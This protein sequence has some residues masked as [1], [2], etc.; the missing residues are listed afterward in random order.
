MKK[1]FTFL[2]L[3]TGAIFCT[4]GQ[5]PQGFKYQTVIR[6]GNSLLTNQL[7][8]I[9]TSILQSS[10][11]GTAMFSQV[12]TI[13][14][15]PY[16]LVNLM[17]G[18]GG[19]DS[20]SIQ[21]IDWS[22]GPYFIKTELD[23]SGGTNFHNMGI[24]QIL[25]VPFAMFS[26]KTNTHA[27]FEIDGTS[28]LPIDTA[29]FEVKDRAGRT[30]FAVY[31]EGAVVYV[32]EGA[33]GAKSGFTVGGRTPGGKGFLVDEIMRVTPD[34][35]RFY[36]AD[37]SKT[38]GAVRGFSVQGRSAG[39]TS[40]ANV[41]Y[42]T[43]DSTRIYT[44][45][46]IAGFGIGNVDKNHT[47]SSYMKINGYNTA[48]GNMAGKSLKH[49][50]WN[51]MMGYQ[52]GMNSTNAFQN[53]FLG[54]NAGMSNTTGDNNIFIGSN[55][56]IFN[57]VGIN[58][59]FIGDSAGYINQSGNYNVYIGLRSGRNS[60]GNANVFVGNRTGYNL[61]QG[62]GNTF[63]GI[64]AGD[65]DYP[66]SD[67]GNVYLGRFAGYNMPGSNQLVISNSISDT[68]T[69][70]IYGEFYKNKLRIN[71]QL[72]INMSATVNAL[73]VNGNAYKTAAGSWLVASDARIKS[74]I[75]EID[76]AQET[77]LKLHPV[78]F[79]YTQEWISKNPGLE[80][81][82]YYN[83]LAQEFLNVFPQ[84]VKSSGQFINGDSK[85]LLQMDSYNA[86][87]IMVKAVQELIL[88]NKALEKRV[89]ELASEMEKLK[90]K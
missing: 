90:Q 10:I 44:R 86:Q 9:K 24:S 62:N 67:S 61:V 4:Y 50:S 6:K 89:A 17:I 33:K 84:S 64:A 11:T 63:V 53:V 77:L 57:T 19:V 8:S 7:V 45:D 38:K 23:E 21:S 72:G 60:I 36:I 20:G 14:T 13:T 42:V 25:S 88:E 66:T 34:S 46:T 43:S 37:S 54:Y 1:L 40:G 52:A 15:N 81:Q 65:A 30:V 71:K 56:G 69:S 35:I 59:S 5:V 55:A 47:I 29:L 31:E 83:F 74:N 39:A 79:R 73:E 28:Q 27:K 75:E 76:N 58:N 32:S 22:M 78:K 80:D 41:F 26:A 68:S 2:L 87:I 12:D 49:G 18:S 70:L 16:G 48:I 85:E 51:T 3:L 82:V